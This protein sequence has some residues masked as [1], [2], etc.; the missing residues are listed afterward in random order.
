[1]ITDDQLSKIGVQKI[2]HRLAIIDEVKAR[3]C[4]STGTI[5]MSASGAA[6]R[7][8]SECLGRYVATG[9]EHEGAVVYR[10]SDGYILYRYSYGTWRASQH[11]IGWFSVLSSVDR[12]QC[13]ASI[14][15]WQYRPSYTVTAPAWQSGDIT[16]RCS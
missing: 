16:V 1:M 9:E 13:P 4:A 11:G 6:A 3:T 2:K 12:A 7:R 14:R 5:T 10:N 15:Q 8:R